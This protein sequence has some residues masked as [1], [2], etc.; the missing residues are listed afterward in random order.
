[1]AHRVWLAAVVVAAVIT[2]SGC[3]HREDEP[4]SGVL[5]VNGGVGAIELRSVHVEAPPDHAYPAG[6]SAVVWFT[7][8]NDGPTVDRLARVASPYAAEVEIWWDRACDGTAEPVPELPL[9]AGRAAAAPET[10][11]AAAPFDAYHLRLV[12]FTRRILAG[13]TVPL[14]FTFASA[15]TLDLVVPVL[16]GSGAVSEPSG[17]C[18]PA[19]TGSPPDGGGAPSRRS[20]GAAQGGSR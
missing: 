16:A 15:G 11:T 17:R 8:L 7:V 1:M 2:A 12:G 5:G 6:A 20:P 10:A 9:A 13:T 4:Q 18:G 19:G 3:N 14:T